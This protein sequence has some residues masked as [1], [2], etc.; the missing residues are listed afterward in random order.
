MLDFAHCQNV[1]PQATQPIAC[2]LFRHRAL[3]NRQDADETGQLSSA[4]EIGGAFRERGA[5][6]HCPLSAIALQQQ[7]PS[8]LQN[9]IW[10]HTFLSGEAGE[11]AGFLN[12]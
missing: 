12:A 9:G 2:Q 7:E 4:W 11:T 10:G 5:K 6:G 8:S 1:V 3:D